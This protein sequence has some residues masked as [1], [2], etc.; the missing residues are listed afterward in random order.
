MWTVSPASMRK[1]WCPST[2][3]LRSPH[4]HPGASPVSHAVAIIEA[5]LAAEQGV[6][7]ITVGYGQCGNLIQ[8]RSRHSRRWRSHGG[9]PE[10]I[11]LR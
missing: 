8:G 9:V 2:G 11:R 6:K 3:A 10:E 5:L 1:N 7:N 4:R